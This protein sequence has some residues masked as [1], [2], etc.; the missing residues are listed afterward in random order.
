[1]PDLILHGDE[2]IRRWENE[3]CISCRC[4]D[5]QCPLISV[6]LEHK[7]ESFAGIHIYSCA[8]YDPNT[9]HPLFIETDAERR[10][11]D[12]ETQIERLRNLHARANNQS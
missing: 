6:L 1:M 10:K 5:E 8:L 9:A 2:G 12:Y 11:V 4:T 3:K 7:I